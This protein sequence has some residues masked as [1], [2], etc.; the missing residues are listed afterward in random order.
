MEISD[1]AM[2]KIEEFENK[3]LSYLPIC[4]AKTQYSFTDDQKLV[5]APDNFKIHIK[6]LK[7]YHGAGFIAVLLGDIMT[8]PGLARNSNYEN[9]DLIDGKVVGLF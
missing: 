9:I 1:N 6:D 5:G 4:V 8:M 7:L 2:K 3:N